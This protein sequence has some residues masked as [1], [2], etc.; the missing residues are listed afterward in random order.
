[1]NRNDASEHAIKTVSNRE[2]AKAN[3][4]K[5][6]PAMFAGTVIFWLASFMTSLLPRLR[7][8]AAYSNW[9]P[10]MVWIGA[11]FMGALFSLCLS[12]LCLRRFRHFH[13][14]R[15]IRKALLIASL[16][17]LIAVVLFELPLML[18]SANRDVY[19]FFVGIVFNAAR[20]LLMGITVGAVNRCALQSA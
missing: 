6:L 18:R 4:G 1:M 20:F 7:Y 16:L 13:A 9:T 12:H 14:D 10:Q 17:L 3:D 8:R 19:Y 2:T 11:F 5:L 15:P